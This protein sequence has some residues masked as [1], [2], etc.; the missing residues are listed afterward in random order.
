MTCGCILYQNNVVAAA[1]VGFPI[2]MFLSKFAVV[3]VE[4]LVDKLMSLLGMLSSKKNVEMLFLTAW[5]WH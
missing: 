4:Y 2:S 1:V 5:F 3:A